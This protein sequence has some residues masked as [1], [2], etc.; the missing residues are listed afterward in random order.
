MLGC[1]CRL[2][3]KKKGKALKESVYS[4]PLSVDQQYGVPYFIT[5][6]WG[7]VTK[8]K[9]GSSPTART[10][11]CT[12]VDRGARESEKLKVLEKDFKKREVKD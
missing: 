5:V 2:P 1:L 9:Q 4:Q 12:R 3:L 8:R 11:I 10:T 7:N 6:Y